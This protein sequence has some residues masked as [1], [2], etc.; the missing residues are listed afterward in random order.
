MQTFQLSLPPFTFQVET[1]ISLVAR[2]ADS[3]Y[4]SAYNDEIDPLVYVDYYLSATYV[5]SVNPLSR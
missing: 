4:G 1:N 5:T 2:N 3:L